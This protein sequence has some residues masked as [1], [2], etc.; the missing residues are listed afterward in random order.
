VVTGIDKLDEKEPD[1]ALTLLGFVVRVNFSTRGVGIACS[2]AP[3]DR[4]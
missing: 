3:S 1:V 4:E 2:D